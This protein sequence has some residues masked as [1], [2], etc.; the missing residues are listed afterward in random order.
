MLKYGVNLE[1]NDCP[2]TLILPNSWSQYDLE[3]ATRILF[4]ECNIPA[5]YVLEEPIGALYGTGNMTGLIVDLGHETIDI[6][7]IYD[8]SPIQPTKKTL[9]LGGKDINTYLTKLWPNKHSASVLTKIKK[10]ACVVA[11]RPDALET[12]PVSI[13]LESQTVSLGVSRS[14]C[15]EV[16]FNPQLVGKTCM[17]LPEAIYACV[18]ASVEPSKRNS[19]WENI[20]LAGGT[21]KL[22]GTSTLF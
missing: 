17:S 19:L 21:S 16:L 4:E 11:P 20:I 9:E 18:M 3:T 22:N 8:N 7:A 12:G 13:N 6:T 5:L 15:C 1:R 2:V 10:E 14:K